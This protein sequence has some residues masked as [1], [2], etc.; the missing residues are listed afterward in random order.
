MRKAF[1][2]VLLAILVCCVPVRGQVD[3]GTITGVVRDPQQAGIPN[4][5]IRFHSVA[6]GRDISISANASGG[7]TSPPLRAG[8]YS[9]TVEAPGFRSEQ[10]QM[11]LELNQRAVLDFKLEIGAATETIQV[12]AVAPLLESES[13][14]IATVQNEQAIRNLPLN[15]RNFNQ[16]IGL[17][18]GVVPAQTQ[19]GAL[20]I[21]A[22]RGTTANGVNGIGFRSNNY[23]VDGLDNSENHNGQ[24]ILIYPPVEAIQ[25]FRI[26]T[27]VPNAEFARGG[28]TINVS[29]KSGSREFHGDMFEFVRNSYLDAKNYFD[30]AGPITPFR[31]NQYGITFG[32]PVIFP[33]FNRK[34][35]N[36]FFFFSWEG[37]RRSQSLTN[38]VSVPLP[39]VK[40][41]NFSGLPQRIYDPLM[42]Q[43]LPNGTIQRTQFPGN[44]I[45]PNRV[46]SVGRNIINLFPDPNLPGLANNYV[47]TLAATLSQS[48]F[49][50]KVDHNFSERD[51]VFFRISHHNT[52]QYTPGALPLP[53]VGSSD[54]STNTY[55]LGQVVVSYTRTLSPTLINEARAGATRL[56]TRAFN[57]NY[58]DNVS[59]TIGISGVN[60]PA[61]PLTSGFTQ[62]NLTGYPTLGDSGFRPAIIT[63]NNFQFNDAVTWIHGSHTLKFGGEVLRR[64]ENLLQLNNLHGIL[65]FGPIYTTNPASPSGT[66]NSLADLLL[67]TPSDGNIAFVTGTTGYRRTDFGVFAQ[68]TWKI[69]PALTLNIGIR[70]DANPGYL[71]EEVNNRMAYFRPDLGTTV[72]VGTNGEP[73]SGT[74]SKWNNVGPRI[75]LAYRLGPNTVIRAAYGLF[76]SPDP[77]P[78]TELGDVNPP[79]VGSVSFTNNQGDFLGARSAA[80]AFVR[81]AG[82]TFSPIG[83]ALKSIDFNLGIPTASQWNFSVEHNLPGQI[84]WSTAYVGTSGKHLI[85]EPN[86]NQP[87]PGPGAAASRRPYPL[88][89]NI[90]YVESAGSSVYHSLQVSAEKR[91]TGGLQ[92]L[93]SYTYSHAI[94]N[95]GFLSA[96]QNLYSLADE[97]GNSD[98]DLRQRFILS[99]TWEIPFGHK[100][101]FGSSLN[102]AADLAVGGWRLNAIASFYSG[103]PFTPTSSVNT[104]NGSGTQRPDRIAD[105]NLPSDQ[106]TVQRWFDIGAFRTPGLYQFGNAG[107]NILFGPGTKQVDMALAKEFGVTESKRFE[108]RAEAFNVSNTPQFNNPNASISSVASGFISSAGSKTTFQRTSRQIQLALKFYF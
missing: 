83:A 100:R 89:N 91:M 53:A 107:R 50:F 56:N 106:Q 90:T 37:Q 31:L 69:S 52:D 99:G 3:S 81:P 57:L 51:Q 25:E 60:N 66:G 5:R 77:V 42:T 17:A 64:Q 12:R 80:Q 13:S 104:L 43:T 98:L 96:P 28:A 105:G 58:G 63:N 4:T 18:T 1:S 41:G 62:I 70:Y 61:D 14:T 76:Y 10:T 79:F 103:L 9:I 46:S 38:L 45:P 2:Q 97:R 48:N 44:I 71:W 20:A 26:Q 65:N 8:E 40:T 22:S 59:D 29:Y 21:T 39:A 27:S 108:F 16:L 88:Y 85:L 55:P 33:G 54:A 92:F 36:T 35:E 6:T 87:A 73:R 47:S 19:A 94:D 82:V 75:G 34:R 23:R 30:P 93:S 11:T 67:G 102:R 74:R 32:G 7:Y 24:G 84:L 95:G 101:K 68:D 78:P 86:I 15:T 72:T 49:D